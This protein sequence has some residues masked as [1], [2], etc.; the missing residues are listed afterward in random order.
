[1]NRNA[2][3]IFFQLNFRIGPYYTVYRRPA[4]R[5]QLLTCIILCKMHKL[6]YWLILAMHVYTMKYTNINLGTAAPKLPYAAT[7]ASLN[8]PNLCPKSIKERLIFLFF[9]EIV[10]HVCAFFQQT[11]GKEEESSLIISY[12]TGAMRIQQA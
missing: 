3:N 11:K 4:I 12:A 1:M 5:L 8:R 10:T 6:R 2:V 9:L 7:H